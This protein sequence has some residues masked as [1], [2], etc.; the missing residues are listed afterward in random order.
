M[1]IMIDD[2]G[3]GDLLFGVVIGAYRSETGEFYYD[4]VDIKYFQ[5]PMFKRKRYLQ[6]TSR[7]VFSILNKLNVKDGE[8][9]YICSGSIFDQAHRDLKTKYNELMHI[10]KIT[11]T[12]QHYTETAYLDEVRNLGYEPTLDR[13]KKRAKSFFH[14]LNWVR[15]DSRRIKYAKT[16]WPRLRRY[17]LRAY[18]PTHD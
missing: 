3:V 7:I 17:N 11:G 16:G 9:I 18:R 13:D 10:S 12:A 4:V 2:A 5:Y 8:P 6:E 14:M 15:R 1:T